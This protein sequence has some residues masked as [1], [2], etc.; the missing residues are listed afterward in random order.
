MGYG[1]YPVGTSGAK[2][3]KGDP[4][5]P[6][7]KGDTGAT[8]PAGSANISG[9]A[10]K[11]L[12]L[13][14]AT[15]GG[16]SQITDDAT[17]ITLG[18]GVAATVLDFI[19][20]ALGGSLPAAA[21]VKVRNTTSSS[22][23]TTVQ[24]APTIEIAGH[25]RV[26]GTDKTMR[27]RISLTPKTS[28][29]LD[30]K[31]EYD[32]G[33]G[34]YSTAFLYTTLTSGNFVAAL[35]AST[36]SATYGAGGFQFDLNGAG[37]LQGPSNGIILVS[38]EAADPLYI[39]GGATSTTDPIRLW[40]NGETKGAS[41]A[42]AVFGDGTTWAERS[43]VMGDGSWNGPLWVVTSTPKTA[44]YTAVARDLIFLNPTGG[45]F[46]LTLPTAVGCAGKSIRAYMTAASANVVTLRTTSGQTISGSAS[47]ALTLGNAV[48]LEIGEFTSD[49]ANWWLSRHAA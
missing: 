45:A 1:S 39:K 17:T 9:T 7:P 21:A 15:T 25:A 46:D 42:I 5:D 4:G 18:D 35:Q 3:D 34:T 13:T 41:K 36:F 14:D 2:G 38:Y 26:S 20:N 16:N 19:R 22:A 40:A 27:I 44:N 48:T 8:G 47:G 28:G 29:N 12:K 49:G 30:F 43:K 31:V 11:V 6:G 24:V 33:G 23:G 37:L 32:T 10:N